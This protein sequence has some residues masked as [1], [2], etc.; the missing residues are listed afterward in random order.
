VQKERVEKI[1]EP[2]SCNRRI[3][4]EIVKIAHVVGCVPNRDTRRSCRAHNRE[5][6]DDK[7]DF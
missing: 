5:E 2:E 4:V 3:E 1:D 6:K 7:A